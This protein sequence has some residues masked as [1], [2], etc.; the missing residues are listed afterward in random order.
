MTNKLTQILGSKYPIIQGGL[1]NIATGQFAA[2]CSNA[3]ALG[4]IGS[5]SMDAAQLREHIAEAKAATATTG[6][7]FGVNIMLMNPHAADLAQVVIDEGIKVVTTGAG[8][9]APFMADWKEAG[10]TVIPVVPSSMLAKKMESLGASAV[11]AE[12]GEAGGHVGDLTT[13]ALVP[14]VCSAVEIPVIAAGG[15]ATGQQMAAAFMLGAC[16]VQVGTCTL[17]S[18]ECPIHENYKQAVVAAKDSSTTV[19]GRI[20]GT[21]VRVIKNQ[22]A[23]AY[24]NKEREGANKEELE[25]FTLGSLR[26]AVVDGDVKTGSIM[27]GQVAGLCNEILPI[28]TIFDVMMND[29]KTTLA[30]ASH[31]QL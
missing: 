2:A 15:I 6:A 30:E 10:I 16:G 26:R 28:A 31:I 27:A 21:P 14:Q 4:L 19:T 9:P 1:A 12:G 22:M 29:A 24:I 7:P 17:V 13:M 3:G 20:A 18:D 5:G 11:I 25:S 8:S 23:R